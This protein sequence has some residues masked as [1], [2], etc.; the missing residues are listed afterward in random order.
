MMTFA[1]VLSFI[2]IASL[3]FAFVQKPNEAERE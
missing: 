3:F 2:A 1:F